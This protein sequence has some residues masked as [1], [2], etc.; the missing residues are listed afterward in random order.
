MQLDLQSDGFDLQKS[1]ETKSLSFQLREMVMSGRYS[2]PLPN[3]WSFL[4]FLYLQ[5]IFIL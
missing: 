2:L 1:L 5:S 3:M 4:I